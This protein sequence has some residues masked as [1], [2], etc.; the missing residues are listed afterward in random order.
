[1]P[2][3]DWSYIRELNQR[4]DA[5]ALEIGEMQAKWI[6]ARMFADKDPQ[7]LFDAVLGLI[8]KV[9]G[10]INLLSGKI[11]IYGDETLKKEWEELLTEWYQLVSNLENARVG[12]VMRIIERL[13]EVKDELMWRIGFLPR[14]KT[15][16]L[17][18]RISESLSV[19]VIDDVYA[20]I[21]QELERL[22]Q[23]KKIDI[24]ALMEEIGEKKEEK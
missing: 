1:M 20:Q 24:S 18:E 2:S 11:K 6:K 16:D 5:L 17:A 22:A 23:E 13:L 4:I 14:E 8:T 19:P 3:G 21:K 12:D 10:M 15:Y 9:Q 7:K